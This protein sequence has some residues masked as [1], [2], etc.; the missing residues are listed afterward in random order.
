[1]V[2]SPLSSSTEIRKKNGKVEKK[3]RI[4]ERKTV[5]DFLPFA[6]TRL[7]RKY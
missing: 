1:M 6:G 2:I 7:R 4:I 5:V 3:E